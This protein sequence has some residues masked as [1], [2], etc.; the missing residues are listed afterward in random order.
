MVLTLVC[1]GLA[2]A[3]TAPNEA[4]ARYRA[5]ILHY[6]LNEFVEALADFKEAYRL[7]PD[8][9]FLFNIA[10]CHRQLGQYTEAARFYR[11]FRREM[12]ASR[13]HA[14]VDRLILEMDKA[15][16]DERAK[17]A[18]APAPAPGPAADAKPQPRTST[19]AVTATQPGGPST[20]SANTL[21]ATAPPREKP[22][23]K[24]GWFWGVVAGG[25]VLVAA[26]VTLG[27]VF[28]TPPRDPKLAFGQVAGDQ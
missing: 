13:D 4:K 25:A 21:T 10:Q 19:T 23:T 15:A 9:A 24:K 8:P 11:S 16:A 26:G 14:E 1:G 18:A 27:V 2:H 6:N 17:Q 22:L 3:E 28:G 12:G 20:P 7:K 5:G